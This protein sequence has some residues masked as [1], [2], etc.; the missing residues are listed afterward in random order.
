MNITS[1]SSFSLNNT[2]NFSW[3]N[4]SEEEDLSDFINFMVLVV[5][6]LCYLFATSLFS[7]F[8]LIFCVVTWILIPKWRT[9]RNYVYANVI[10]CYAMSS[11]L[12]YGLFFLEMENYESETVLFIFVFYFVNA[13]SCWLFIGSLL[14]YMDIVVVFQ[15]N[16]TRK[17]L[18]ANGFC[19]GVPSLLATLH[20]SG[21]LLPELRIFVFLIKDSY[22]FSGLMLAVNLL[23]YM[24]VLCGLFKNTGLT[25]SSRVCQKV[26][27]AT[28]TFLLS[29]APIL[30]ASVVSMPIEKDNRYA[31]VNLISPSLPPLQTIIL[32]VCFLLMKSNRVSWKQRRILTAR[33][34]CSC[35]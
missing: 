18:K 22:G 13:S 16:V 11:C 20:I 28:F 15:R 5:F 23:L 25:V 30:I 8:T 33:S 17:M 27:V 9:F 26:Q 31:A 34:G 24:K 32:N 1:N 21:E 35:C 14:I 12:F 7:L 2:S 10:F 3:D 19:W 29:G 6:F 4:A